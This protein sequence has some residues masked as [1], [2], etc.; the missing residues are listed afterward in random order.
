MSRRSSVKKPVHTIK[1]TGPGS[2]L[3]VS[4]WENQI[5]VESGR[6]ITVEAVS[7]SRSYKDGADWHKSQNLRKQDLLVVAN[8]LQR[9][10]NYLTEE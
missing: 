2:V 7:F 3:E 6:E 9:T 5:Q 8:M 4:V 1:V 10:F